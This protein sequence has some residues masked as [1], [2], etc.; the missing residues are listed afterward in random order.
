MIWRQRRGWGGGG[1][2]PHLDVGDIA[3]SPDGTWVAYM[4][5]DTGNKLYHLGIEEIDTHKV[6][7]WGGH[8]AGFQEISPTVI[9]GNHRTTL[10]FIE[11]DDDEDEG[12]TTTSN[13]P[14]S[15]LKGH[16][17]DDVSVVEHHLIIQGR[18]QPS[19]LP[20][21][22]WIARLNATDHIGIESVVPDDHCRIPIPGDS[23]AVR[24]G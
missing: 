22:L 13:N 14:V 24:R 12:D 23:Q 18:L 20:Q 8:G 3:V 19:G 5:D 6:I 21:L 7:F 11:S 4:I 17:L 2:Q 9:F 15:I 16:S 10:F 1:A